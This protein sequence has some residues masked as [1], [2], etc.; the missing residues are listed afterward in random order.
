M[1]RCFQYCLRQDM[2]RDLS[3][4]GSATHDM[5]LYNREAVGKSRRLCAPVFVCQFLC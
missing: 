4:E 5:I 1:A 2:G 3:R